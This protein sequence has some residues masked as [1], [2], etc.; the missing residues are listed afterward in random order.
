MHLVFFACFFFLTLTA[1]FWNWTLYEFLLKFLTLQSHRLCDASSLK[2]L[3]QECLNSRDFVETYRKQWH[4]H[5]TS[6]APLFFREVVYNRRAN[7]APSGIV[8]TLFW[9]FWKVA[10]VDGNQ[11]ELTALYMLFFNICCTEIECL[12]LCYNLQMPEIDVPGVLAVN[13]GHSDLAEARDWWIRWIQE[14]LCHC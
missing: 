14:I 7:K 8:K 2:H 6:P 5:M 1:W 12:L 3:Q 4:R 11:H 10:H 9:F 13:S